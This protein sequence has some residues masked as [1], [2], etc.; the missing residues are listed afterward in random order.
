MLLENGVEMDD[1]MDFDDGV[2]GGDNQEF[3]GDEYGFE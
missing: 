3:D 2:M 1:D